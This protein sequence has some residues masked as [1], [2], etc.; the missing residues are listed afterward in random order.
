MGSGHFG[1]SVEEPLSRLMNSYTAVRKVVH[2]L[3]TS[4]IDEGDIIKDPVALL[5]VSTASSRSVI[6]VLA[7]VI[8]G[9]RKQLGEVYVKSILLD[10]IKH[11]PE[12]DQQIRQA[13]NALEPP[14]PL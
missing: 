5:D 7:D 14:L 4:I 8:Q 10:V 9:C 12:I 11:H 13:A 6:A 3:V 1:R 2:Y